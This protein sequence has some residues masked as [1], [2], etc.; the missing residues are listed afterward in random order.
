MNPSERI[1][2]LERLANLR[3]SGALTD[4]EFQQEKSR[5]LENDQPVATTDSITTISR[6]TV[7]AP[8]PE[9]SGEHDRTGPA[10]PHETVLDAMA[11]KRMA[12]VFGDSTDYYRGKFLK[13]IQSSEVEHKKIEGDW[14]AIEAR[15]LRKPSINL[16]GMIFG[17]F[18][19][20]YR[21]LM[22]GWM[23][24]AMIVALTALQYVFDFDSTAIDAGISS[25]GIAVFGLLGNGFLLTKYL[26]LVRA[27]ASGDQIA[28]TLKPSPAFAVGIPLV[29]VSVYVAI[30]MLE[31]FGNLAPSKS[32]QN[33]ERATLSPQSG[34][35][36]SNATDNVG[37]YPAGFRNS[38]V[39]SCAPSFSESIRRSNP[40]AA[41]RIDGSDFCECL[42]AK[43][44]RSISLAEM[45][46]F[47]RAVVNGGENYHPIIKAKISAFSAECIADVTQ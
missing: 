41:E 6:A 32:G 14:K 17:P 31:S 8:S 1:A 18:W 9:I 10:L 26:S 36:G 34:A 44:E 21:R 46:A 23:W 15:V 5:I 7:Q 24:L 25:G 35:E 28:E 3:Q 39:A 4:Q 42:V 43:A 33:S 37:R 13:I 12:E 45:S 40:A 38:F 22:M 19:A 20:I 29:V 47:E 16:W 2:A 27:G 30:L 11:E